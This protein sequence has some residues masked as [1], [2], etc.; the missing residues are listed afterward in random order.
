MERVVLGF[1]GSPASEAAL[2]WTA[3]RARAE[4]FELDIVLV[5]NMFLSDRVAADRILDAASRHWRDLVPGLPAN[6]VRLDGLMPTTLTEA[7]RGAALLV[8]GIETGFRMRSALSGWLPLRAAARSGAPTVLVPAG[9]MA[10][11]DPVTVG[12][13]EDA[14]SASALL[15]AAR[16]A[17]AA[18]VPLRILHSWLMGSSV[19]RGHASALPST[20]RVAAEHERILDAAVA[21]VRREYPGLGVV[22]EL[23][24][25][26]PTSALSRAADRS[27]MVV[28]GTHGRGVVVG[29]F[30]GS[31]GLDLVGSLNRTI[32][33][34]PPARVLV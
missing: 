20:Q 28:I 17:A 12:L 9:W 6:V 26:N 21:E 4:S 19:L 18:D 16:A 23:V 25:D 32:C 30:I 15:F 13:D 29:G 34:V 27:S 24:R 5:T 33:V 3:E 22:T 1:D 8:L 10:S 7:A 11:D 31:I 2:E 14:S